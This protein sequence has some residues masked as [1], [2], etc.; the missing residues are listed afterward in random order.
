MISKPRYFI[1]ACQNMILYRYRIDTVSISYRYSIDI[2]CKNRKTGCLWGRKTERQVLLGSENR[3]SGELWGRSWVSSGGSWGDFGGSERGRGRPPAAE[4]FFVIL[5]SLKL[6]DFVKTLIWFWNGWKLIKTIFSMDFFLKFDLIGCFRELN[7]RTFLIFVSDHFYDNKN[8][9][10]N[11]KNDFG[12]ET[13]KSMASETTWESMAS[14]T[15]HRC[16][17]S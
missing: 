9:L 12:P 8:R 15:E 10:Y 5:R 11:K 3:R 7:V 13:R 1:L 4:F 14:Q 6:W 2:A 17:G 16:G